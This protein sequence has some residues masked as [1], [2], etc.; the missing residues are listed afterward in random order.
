MKG[1]TKIELTD[2]KT[3]KVQVIE[4]DNIVTD[5]F[6]KLLTPHYP[7][8]WTW[9]DTIDI[10]T[11]GVDPNN[12][13]AVNTPF[14]D[15]AGLIMFKEQ[16][17]ADP[18]NYRPNGTMTAHADKN[19]YIGPDLTRGSFNKNLSSYSFDYS[20]DGGETKVVM[21]WDFGLEQG[22]GTIGTVCLCNPM[23]AKIG[24][25]SNYV[26]PSTVEELGFFFHHS[27]LPRVEPIFRIQE[28]FDVE[29]A[30]KVNGTTLPASIN[31]NIFPIYLNTEH[32][33]VVCID[34]SLIYNDCIRFIEI[35]TNGTS[36]QP[37]NRRV[38]YST[39]DNN[40][41]Y[42]NSTSF[43]H[44]LTKFTKCWVHYLPLDTVERYTGTSRPTTY[45]TNFA[46]S[47]A[48]CDFMCG[49][50]GN[51]NFWYVKNTGFYLNDTHWSYSNTA[52][53]AMRF[54]W[55]KNETIKLCR[56]NLK[57]FETTDFIITNTTGED[58]ITVGCNSCE[59][60]SGIYLPP[61]LANITVVK[62][63]FVFHHSNGRYYAINLLNNSDV[64]EFKYA[65]SSE[66]VVFANTNGTWL[67]GP[68]NSSNRSRTSVNMIGNF[69]FVEPNHIYFCKT[70]LLSTE[71]TQLLVADTDNFEVKYV[72]CV[73]HVNSPR[74][75]TVKSVG[76]NGF[77]P[78]GDSDCEQ[79]LYQNLYST[80][81]VWTDVQKCFIHELSWMQWWKP[82]GLITINRL[83]D[84]VTKT[85]DM[86]M[87]I[88]YTLTA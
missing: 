53:E 23:D 61:F 86:T 7:F 37:I 33:K 4:D 12:K 30:G 87:R 45:D 43:N 41:S 3:G 79:I 82:M 88:T 63:Y 42:S 32:G 60:V 72:N 65:D 20:S 76:S 69:S 55:K 29:T 71:T 17:D 57:T 36:V 47:L 18:S 49:I 80:G 39:A 10:G 68:G 46:N 48:R 84:P 14:D 83:A 35:D 66:P 21:V 73:A 1:H 85:A 27:E 13:N 15:F 56:V 50:D 70:G 31:P 19:T 16:L 28:D 34:A 59:Y 67:N 75:I 64:K 51:G 58:H 44:R 81:V 22:N 6:R 2:V 78:L 77:V 25:G 11:V 8:V 52:P 62:D 9:N 40:I 74:S 24:Y 26:V 54:S 38:L 5:Y